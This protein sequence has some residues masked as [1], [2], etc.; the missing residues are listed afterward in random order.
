MEPIAHRQ[1]PSLPI[2]HRFSTHHVL[3]ESLQ[4]ASPLLSLQDVHR[5]PVAVVA[6]RLQDKLSRVLVGGWVGL[7]ACWRELVSAGGCWWV[8]MSAGEWR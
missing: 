4:A 1:Q 7:G 2:R 6:P 8:V 5:L 3:S